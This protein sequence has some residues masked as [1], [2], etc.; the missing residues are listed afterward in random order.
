MLDE[1][2]EI[3]QNKGLTINDMANVLGYKSSSTYSKKERGVIPITINEAI[4]ICQ[5]LEISPI[6]FF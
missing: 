4:K 2:R 1:I 3:R 5:I 6:K